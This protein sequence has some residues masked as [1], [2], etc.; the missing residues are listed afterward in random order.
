MKPKKRP[1][2]FV[3]LENDEGFEDYER[4]MREYKRALVHKWQWFLEGKLSD[5]TDLGLKPIPESMWETMAILFENQQA[6][7]RGGSILEATTKNDVTLPV[8]YAL[9]IIRKVYP[10][11]IVSRIA[12]IQPLPLMS[13]GTGQIF[14]LDFLREDKGAG[15]ESL[16]VLDSDYAKSEEN[17][18]PKR[19]KMTITSDTIT[20]VKHILAATWST[21]VEEDVRGVMGLDVESELISSAAHEIL[22]EL[23]YECI[24]EIMAGATAG[25]VNWSWTPDTGYLAK[26]WYETLW[27]ALIDAEDNIFGKRYRHADYVVCGR[28]VSKYLRKAG[29][30]KPASPQPFDEFI[31]GI[32]HEGVL[33][34]LWDIYTTVFMNTN[35]GLMGV[36]PRS[37]IDTGY[38][39]APYIPL[40]PMPLVY[41]SFDSSDGTYKNVDK[42]TRNIRTRNAHKMV[43]GDLFATINIS[44]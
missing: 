6:V 10:A 4:Q 5:G 38:I 29:D 21:E 11:L 36:Y 33:E 24:N 1:S 37:P 42:W 8:R 34:G 20:A 40:T 22:Q 23:D 39:F 13:G 30:F 15:T 28:N 12:S 7:S 31:V 35:Q 16:T 41:A 44:A 14:Y 32:R 19:V 3:V 25:N 26:E 27:H 17:A 9:P 2:P 18:V 43:V